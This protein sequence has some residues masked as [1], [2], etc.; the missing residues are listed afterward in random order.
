MDRSFLSQLPVIAASRNFICVRL[1][2]YESEDE[3]AYL[4]SFAAGRSGQLENTVF[5]I[6]SPD[7]E[8]KL[9]RAARGP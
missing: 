5:C 1:A 6:L 2:T 7:G 4:R 8:E 3:A 9:I